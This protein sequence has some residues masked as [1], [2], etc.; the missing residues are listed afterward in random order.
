MDNPKIVFADEPTGNLDSKT[1][2][3]ILNIITGLV[4]EHGQTLISVTHDNNIAKYGNKVVTLKD[5]SIE[6]IE[7][8]VK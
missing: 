5:G 6:S 4:K 8:V 1:S 3:E 7:E 2:T